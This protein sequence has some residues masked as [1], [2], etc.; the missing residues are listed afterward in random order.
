[1]TVPNSPCFRLDANAVNITWHPSQLD[2][3]DVLHGPNAA[4][5]GEFSAALDQANEAHV[6]LALAVSDAI[7]V[8]SNQL[9]GHRFDL[10]PD[11]QRNPSIWMPFNGRRMAQASR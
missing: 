5:D 2:G 8:E 11:S 9:K 1:M 7:L 6:L 3:I 10:T 4:P